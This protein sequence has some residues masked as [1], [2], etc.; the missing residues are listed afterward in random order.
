[1]A[2]VNRPQ[3][4]WLAPLT[5][6]VL[7][8]RHWFWKSV[9]EGLWLGFGWFLPRLCWK[10]KLI[11]YKKALQFR[12][13]LIYIH[14]L[15]LYTNHRIEKNLTFY[16]TTAHQLSSIYFLLSQ[17]AMFN[18]KREENINMASFLCVKRLDIFTNRTWRPVGLTPKT[19]D[20]T[21]INNCRISFIQLLPTIEL[22]GWGDVLKLL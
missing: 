3:G 10:S 6:T 8:W 2:S 21:F 11:C 18:N 15:N 17:K 20:L 19:T 22:S 9:L 13:L 14:P 16:A 4:T 12:L 1:M 7:I 5:F